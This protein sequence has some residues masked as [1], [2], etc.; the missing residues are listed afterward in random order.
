[1]GIVIIYGPPGS[2]KTTNGKKFMKH[3]K[4]TRVIEWDERKRGRALKD[5]DLALTNLEPPFSVPGARA[6]DIETA[7]RAIGRKGSNDPNSGA[8]RG[9]I[10]GGPLE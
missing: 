2:G 4:C 5:G 3:Y 6:V 1:M 9:P 7:K 10:A 8:A